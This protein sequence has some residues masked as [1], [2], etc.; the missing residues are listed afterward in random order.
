MKNL[1]LATGL[2]MALVQPASAEVRINGFAN[3]V[4]GIT[5]SDDSLYGF[6][7][8]IDFSEQSLFALQVSSNVSDKLTATAQLLARGNE[9]FDVE[10]E[11]AYLSYQ[12]NDKVAITAGRVRTPLFRYSASLDVGYSQHWISAPNGM[13][14][15]P[16]NNLDGIRIDYSTFQGDWEIYLQGAYGTF[17][18]PVF[19][20]DFE[21]KN[22]FVLTAEATYDWFKVRGVY[23]VAKS[24]LSGIAEAEAALQAISTASQP[25]A[26]YLRLDD[27]TSTFSGV[28]IDI[29]HFTWFIGSEYTLIDI[30]DSFFSEQTAFYVTAGIRRGKWTPAVTYETFDSNNDIKGLSFLTPFPAPVQQALL[31]AVAGVQVVNMSEYDILSASVRYDLEA[32]IALKAE[33]TKRNDDLDSQGDATL[34]RFAV[35][36]VF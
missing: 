36:Y 2:A 31:P 7:D 18:N 33:L 35:N 20:G 6:S 29:D 10:F 9:D 22:T 25:L 13:Y 21:G 34:L 26:E 16:A 23:G 15:V 30:E 28:G 8:E 4:G 11:W 3:L 17:S 5:S 32:N 19:G 27:D 24:T 1:Y 12:V 14:N